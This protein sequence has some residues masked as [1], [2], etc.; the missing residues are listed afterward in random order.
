MHPVLA[1]EGTIAMAPRRGQGKD[2]TQSPDTVGGTMR[3]SRDGDGRE[4]EP[5]LRHAIG[6]SVVSFAVAFQ[7]GVTA[8]DL[9]CDRLGYELAAVAALALFVLM[10]SWRAYDLL[11]GKIADMGLLFMAYQS[12]NEMIA[13]V[14]VRIL[15]ALAI[16]ESLSRGLPVFACGVALVALALPWADSVAVRVA[17]R[18]HEE[19]TLDG[20]TDSD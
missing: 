5:S 19:Q 7:L 9:G 3:R 15:A 6:V 1:F 2:G 11:I 12:G 20:Q 17:H 18:V 13:R 4:A 10:A 8:L 14:S 16:I